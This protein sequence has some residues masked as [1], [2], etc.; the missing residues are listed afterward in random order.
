MNDPT[1]AES[2]T[3]IFNKARDEKKTGGSGKPATPTTTPDPTSKHPTAGVK[4][5]QS[6]S[7]T[8][9]T[10]NR[11]LITTV[12]STQYILKLVGL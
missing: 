6:V 7:V 2:F 4:H 11:D 12:Y 8:F 5:L 3:V 10:V 1:S 9:F